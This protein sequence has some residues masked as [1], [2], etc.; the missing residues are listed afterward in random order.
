[1]FYAIKFKMI[2]TVFSIELQNTVTIHKYIL[3]TYPVIIK[4]DTI[5]PSHTVLAILKF[6][7]CSYKLKKKL[8]SY[9]IEILIIHKR[10]FFNLR[11]IKN[12]LIII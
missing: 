3:W 1:M 2:H 12:S 4:T 7:I 5:L 11:F 10:E 8:I 6:F 9:F